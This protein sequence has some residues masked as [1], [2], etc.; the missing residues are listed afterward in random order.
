[1]IPVILTMSFKLPQ[2]FN[3]LPSAALVPFSLAA[4]EALFHC[5]DES[6]GCYFV[7]QGNVRLLRRTRD[8]GE[9]LIHLARTGTTFAEAAIFAP[10]YHCE[11]VALSQATGLLL[12]KACI[13][14][15][16]AN[17]IDFARQLS[18]SFARSV[19]SLRRTI[20]IRA[21]RPARERVLAA[22]GDHEEAGS[23]GL[24]NLPP[25]KSIA[26][27][28]GLT[29]EAF[30]RAVAELVKE[31]RLLRAGHGRLRFPDQD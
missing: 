11:A 19:Q 28:I 21:I 5:G 17:D 15:L 6:R 4:G 20:E 16:F 7:V 8:G 13:E 29:H 12:R 22:I 18:I 2:P 31:G 23:A 10:H 14:R 25:L 30:Y 24:E 1:M 27:Q 9:T 3:R 26:Q